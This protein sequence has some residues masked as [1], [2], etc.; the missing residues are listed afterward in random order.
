MRGSGEDALTQKIQAQR[1]GR[2]CQA[3]S[4][5]KCHIEFLLGLLDFVGRGTAMVAMRWINFD[6]GLAL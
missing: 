6:S 2:E 3:M 5:T 1:N 4:C